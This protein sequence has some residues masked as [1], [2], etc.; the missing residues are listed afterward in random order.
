MTLHVR[1]TVLPC[2]LQES[3]SFLNKPIVFR[4]LTDLFTDTVLNIS[5]KPILSLK[6]ECGAGR[7]RFL[8]YLK[9][10]EEST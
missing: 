6:R 5:E 1:G 10:C 8:R 4:V 9:K 2:L 7:V 3:N